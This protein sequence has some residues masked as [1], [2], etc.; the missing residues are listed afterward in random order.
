MLTVSRRIRTL[1]VVALAATGV[2]LMSVLPASAQEYPPGPPFSIVCPPSETPSGNI[3]PGLERICTLTGPPGQVFDVSYEYDGKVVD[4]GTVTTDED[5]T[6]VF[7]L[8]LERD[9]VGR[10]V[11]VTAV[12][13][14]GEEAVTVEDSFR[15]AG[16]AEPPID[17]GEPVTPETGIDATLLVGVGVLLLGAGF[18]ALRRR[19]GRSVSA[20]SETTTGT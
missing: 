4:F 17:P 11:T 10:V 6:V 20:G 16:A 2:L 5:G 15:V 9:A 19:E 8:V 3:P 13:Q 18:V 7:D 1:T 12:G 14:D